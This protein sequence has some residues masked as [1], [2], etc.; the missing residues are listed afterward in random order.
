MAMWIAFIPVVLWSVGAMFTARAARQLGAAAANRWRLV[1]AVVVL[2]AWTT[3]GPGW[4]K[5]LGAWLRLLLSGA[6]GLG[7]GD[8]SMMAA[9]RRIGPR[10][11]VLMITCLAVPVAAIVEWLWLGTRLTPREI[12]LG[13]GILAG[14]LLAVAPGARIPAPDRASLLG[15]L[16]YGLFAAI[17]QG[18]GVALSRAA[19]GV[20]A[21]D[22]VALHGVSAAAQRML[23]GLAC[24]LLAEW[25]S[26]VG[27]AVTPP[28]ALAAE[29]MIPQPA[30]TSRKALESVVV[31]A[32]CG[33]IVGLSAYQWALIRAPGALVQS[34]V[35]LV[36]VAVIPLAW[37]LEGDLPDRRGLGGAALA[38]LCAALLAFQ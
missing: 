22:G 2:S 19:Y 27:L 36:P 3:F 10:V 4:P 26:Q 23:G 18:L 20:A 5:H 15:G 7:L 38:C 1:I 9:Y 37:R 35:S 21:A 14:V 13:S 34:I 8:L 30:P 28:V 32:F 6:V 33:P 12:L 25:I 17:G 11:T 16:M 29:Q 24:T 31:A